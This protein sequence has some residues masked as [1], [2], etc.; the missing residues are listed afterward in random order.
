M[1]KNNKKIALS[2]T[3]EER[4]QIASDFLIANLARSSRITLSQY[5]PQ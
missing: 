3:I 4:D 5:S 1:Y 2:L